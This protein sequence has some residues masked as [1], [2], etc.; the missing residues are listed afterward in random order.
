[1]MLDPAPSS[2]APIADE[3]H[4]ESNL[5]PTSLGL[6]LLPTAHANQAPNT[7]AGHPTPAPNAPYQNKS[8]YIEFGDVVIQVSPSEANLTCT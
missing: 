3:S 7:E 2:P 4:H 6:E 1:M 8:W 5:P